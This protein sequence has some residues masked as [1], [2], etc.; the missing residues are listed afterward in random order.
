MAN[1]LSSTGITDI[2]VLQAAILHDTVEDTHTTL[3]EISENFGPD[4]ARIVEECTDNTDLSGPRRKAE[5]L[6]TAPY[7]SREAHQVK[8]AE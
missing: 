5:Q 6:R 2:R 4:V 7:K 1:F 8:L 3:T